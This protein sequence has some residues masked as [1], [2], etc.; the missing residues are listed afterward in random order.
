VQTA[1]TV[2]AVCRIVVWRRLELVS[3]LFLQCAIALKSVA[4]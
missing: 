1:G 4:P 2:L 3:G